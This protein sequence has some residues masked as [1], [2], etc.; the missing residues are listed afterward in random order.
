M[1]I[2]I[3]SGHDGILLRDFIRG[4]L[5]YSR[6]MLI[7]L[8]NKE[9]GIRLNGEKV[10]VRARL[11]AGD[12]L[13]LSVDDGAEDINESIEPVCLPLDIVF[14]DEYLI[15]VNKGALVPSH[16]SRHH[17]G[18]TLANALA[19]YFES[20][21][22]AFVFRAANRLD[23]GTSGI[24]LIAKNKPVSFDLAR[25]IKENKITKEYTAVV[26][27]AP[28]P[29]T[30]EIITHIRRA[31]DSILL[32]RVCG[33]NDGGAYAH[34]VYETLF[35]GINYSAVKIRLMTG[36]THQI[37]LHFSHIGCAVAG[38]FLYGTEG[39]LGL[40]HQALHAGFVSLEHPVTK[41]EL[42]LKCSPP[43]DVSGIIAMI[44]NGEV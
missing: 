41:K 26:R 25:K 11:S 24:M 8:K 16:P 17:Q 35:A 29:P 32:R 42:T 20:K 9:D 10:T 28:A 36:R 14:E 15:A 12:E 38:D 23:S 31:P 30:G 43:E 34:T 5:G 44:V 40:A 33:E 3:D 27:G 18:D 37:R 2:I 4:E 39:E 22:E 1:K 21:K 7:R 6:A 19:Y 13:L